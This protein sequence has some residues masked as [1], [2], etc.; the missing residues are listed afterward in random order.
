MPIYECDPWREQYFAAVECPPD[1]HIPT[2]DIDAY[3]LNPRHR[4]QTVFLPKVAYGCTQ[5]A[6]AKSLEEI[7]AVVTE[8]R[9]AS[10]KWP[11][12]NAWI[13]FL[14]CVHSCQLIQTH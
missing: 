5:Q 9:G 6:G 3:R 11:V 1:V 13:S 10:D 2:D 7:A 14:I 12:M 4:E 8:W